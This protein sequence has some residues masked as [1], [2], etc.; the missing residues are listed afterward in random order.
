M[1]TLVHGGDIYSAREKIHTEIIDFS[2][3]INPLGIP[4]GV[5]EALTAAIPSCIHYPDPLNRRLRKALA[6]FE[7]V[8]EDQLVLGNGAADVIFRLCL[9]VK[10]KKA[11]L[12]AP[13]FQEYEEALRVTETRITFYDL[14]EEEEFMVT[15]RF[16]KELKEDYDILFLCNPNNPT[17]QTIDKDL[18]RRIVKRTEE[19][20]ILLVMDECFQ[21]FLEEEDRDSL[22]GLIGTYPHLFILKAFTKLYAIPGVRLG[23]GIT[24][25]R[26][27]LQGMERSGQPW[28]VS[29]LAEE[30][31]LAALSEEEYR[32]KTKLL[33]REE[34]AFL[35]E[36]LSSLGFRV[37]GSK[38]NYLF[39][40]KK[41]AGS[42]KPYLEQRGILVRSCKNY[43]GLTEEYL[44]IA[45]KDRRSN[46]CL[47]KAL[48][49][50]EEE[51]RHG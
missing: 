16:L 9:S 37:I 45:V 20:G 12:L 43:R 30:A 38:A 10:P 5:K 34:R 15:E 17:G 14:R 49:D 40:T 3:N 4:D 25:N 39:F 46:E 7:G 24:G 27:I 22:T 11:L 41:G 32:K 48:G 23:Y 28:S 47:L 6:L 44:R 31:G 18:L 29:V 33:I 8:G 19:L 26:E 13:G 2:A 51:R 42:V 50:W 35:K 1:K 21:D 36:G